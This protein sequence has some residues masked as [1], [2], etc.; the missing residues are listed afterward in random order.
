MFFFSVFSEVEV[1]KVLGSRSLLSICLCL[2]EPPSGFRKS[3]SSQLKRFGVETL[4]NQPP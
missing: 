1:L 3:K 4:E 2:G